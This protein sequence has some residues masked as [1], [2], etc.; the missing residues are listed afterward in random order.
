M[1]TSPTTSDDWCR[2]RYVTSPPYWD[3]LNEFF[4]EPEYHSSEE[5]ESNCDMQVDSL[6]DSQCT[7][8]SLTLDLVSWTHQHNVT[9][10]ALNDLLLLL[11]QH[12]HSVHKDTCTVLKTPVKCCSRKRGLGQNT[13]CHLTSIDLLVNLDGPPCTNHPTYRLQ[14]WPIL[15]SFG[16]YSPF[17][18][19]LCCAKGKP[20]CVNTYMDNFLEEYSLLRETGT[21]HKR[22]KAGCK[23]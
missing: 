12:G 8:E 20:S 17:V 7:S 11:S 3:W 4:D 15:C 22:E 19:A 21:N 16:N 14:L 13:D 23:Y 2:H 9:R 5:S 6:S 1:A 10:S 18:V